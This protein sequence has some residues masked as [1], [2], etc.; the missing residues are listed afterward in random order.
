MKADPCGVRPALE[1]N[2]RRD[3][4]GRLSG[5]EVRGLWSLL[6]W[7]LGQAAGAPGAALTG[8][9]EW[10]LLTVLAALDL[11]GAR[12]ATIN[13]WRNFSPRSNMFLW[14]GHLLSAIQASARTRRCLSGKL[15]DAV[16]T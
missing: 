6:L 15:P 1:K 5:F 10:Q 14:H 16:T 12:V 3:A 8:R 13:P 11:V 2:A 7:A 9:T 4:W